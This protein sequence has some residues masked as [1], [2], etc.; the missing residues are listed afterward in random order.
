MFRQ[1]TDVQIGCSR[2]AIS[3][4]F[5]IF[6]YKTHHNFLSLSPRLYFF[7]SNF[8]NPSSFLFSEHFFLCFF[9]Y[10]SLFLFL[11]IFLFVPPEPPD[12]IAL[13]AD[14]LVPLFFR[15]FAD[16][17]LPLGKRLRTLPSRSS[18]VSWVAPEAPMYFLI[19]LNS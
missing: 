5:F 10:T 1:I 12:T 19:P 14:A 16:P 15:R 17:P 18:F 6:R 2:L 4:Y 11:I 13:N 9:P 7:V 3:S 8:S